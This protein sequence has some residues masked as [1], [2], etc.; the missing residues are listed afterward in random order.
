ML[1][2]IS[3]ISTQ[4]VERNAAV[5]QHDNA[6]A[7]KHEETP[8][9]KHEDAVEVERSRISGIV[10]RGIKPRRPKLK[11]SRPHT[12]FYADEKVFRL[13]K[14][15]AIVEGCRPHDVIM[16]GVRLVFKRYGYTLEKVESGE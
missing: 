9:V 11:S 6:T 8:V 14:E 2:Q 3:D 16:E 15:I 4:T 13:L 1:E 12:S 5:V 10:R 7:P